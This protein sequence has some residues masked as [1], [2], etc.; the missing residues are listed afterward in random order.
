MNITKEISISRDSKA[1]AIQIVEKKKGQSLGL[2]LQFDE[3]DKVAVIYYIVDKTMTSF[4][5]GDQ[6]THINN[7]WVASI[8]KISTIAGSIY[9]EMGKDIMFKVK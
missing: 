5:V 9:T 8:Q 6:V 4:C 2:L 3:L 7:T 1:D